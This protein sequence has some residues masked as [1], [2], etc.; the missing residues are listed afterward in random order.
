MGPL[1]WLGHDNL[2]I[3]YCNFFGRKGSCKLSLLSRGWNLWTCWCCLCHRL[4]STCALAQY[5]TEIYFIPKNKLFTI[6]NNWLYSNSYHFHFLA[7]LICAQVI[8]SFFTLPFTTLNSSITYLDISLF[9]LLT[10]TKLF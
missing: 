9:L 8:I 2:H 7:P 5:G 10:P 6:Y 3:D 4:K 1:F